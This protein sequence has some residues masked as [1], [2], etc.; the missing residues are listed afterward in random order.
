MAID[1]VTT[2]FEPPV[3]RGL[4]VLSHLLCGGFVA[5]LGWTSL[6]VIDAMEGITF[7]SLPLGQAALYWSIP[8]GSGLMLLALIEEIRRALQR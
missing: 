2:R 5:V 4:T 1:L 3:R 8:I 6:A 7:V